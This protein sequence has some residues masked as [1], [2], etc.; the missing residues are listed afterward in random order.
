MLRLI[1][2]V[3][4]SFKRAVRGGAA[5]VGEN[6]HG[7]RA[8]RFAERFVEDERV[9]ATIEL[10]DRP[11]AAWRRAQRG[12]S[13]ER[14]A[15]TRMMRRVPDAELLLEFVELDASTEGKSWEPVSW[16]R[17]ALEQGGDLPESARR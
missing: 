11:Y 12:S 15:I 1:A 10:H 4:D 13:A 17:D 8:R 14:R 3:H 5:K 7:M 2:L 9:L 16:F 6:H